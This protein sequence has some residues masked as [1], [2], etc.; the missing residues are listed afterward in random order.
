MLGRLVV[1]EPADYQRWLEAHSAG[2]SLAA[3]GEARF[4]DLGCSGCHGPR[5]AVAAPSLDGL[6]GQ[7]VRLA[8]GVTVVADERYL[9]DSIVLP[10]AE[11]TAG[12]ASVMPSYAGQVSEADI[13]ELVAYIKSLGTRA[14]PP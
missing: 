2:P 11:V 6:F 13:V 7:P 4:R 8:S 9:H 14:R 1:L 3:R 12:F 5:S 10:S